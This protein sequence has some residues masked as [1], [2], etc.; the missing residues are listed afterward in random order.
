MNEIM[1]VRMELMNEGFVTRQ[2]QDRLF[3]AERCDI[4][5]HLP[6]R[7]PKRRRAQTEKGGK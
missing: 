3:A 7:G 2:D 1:R 5:Y 6:K 4:L